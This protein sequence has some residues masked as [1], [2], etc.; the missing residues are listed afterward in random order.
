MLSLIQRLFSV[1][2]TI[3]FKDGTGHWI[4][5]TIDKQGRQARIE[6]YVD[7]KDHQQIVIL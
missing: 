5:K 6:R 3:T 7:D 2:S 1:K 4:Q